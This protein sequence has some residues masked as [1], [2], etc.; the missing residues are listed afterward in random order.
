[1]RTIE[2][3]GKKY[4]YVRRDEAGNGKK[5]HL[6]RVIEALKADEQVNYTDPVPIKK[7]RNVV[8]NINRANPSMKVR[9][10]KSETGLTFVC[11]KK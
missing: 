10:I 5:S 3:D 1:M 11:Y 7:A 4:N 9:C 6:R 2:I 8:C